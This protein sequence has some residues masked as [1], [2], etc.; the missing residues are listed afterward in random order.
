MMTKAEILKK[1]ELRQSTI[2]DYLNCPLL[3]RYKHLEEI[4]ESYRHSAALHGTALHKVIHRLHTEDWNLDLERAYKKAL[5]D[6]IEEEETPVNW[7]ETPE[8][9]LENAVEILTGYRNNPVNQ[10]AVVL[11][12][13]VPF[14]VKVNGN[15]FTGTIDQVRR[16]PDKTVE[17]LDLKSSK[18]Q[19]SI[20]F[21]KNDWQLNLYLYA[22]LNGELYQD[23]EWIKAGITP[24]YVGWY[25]L[26]HHEI[27][28]RST[29]NGKAGEEKGEPLIKITKS[30]EDMKLFKAELAHLLKVMLKDWHF[31]NPNHCQMCAMTAYCNSRSQEMYD[32]EMTDE[33]KN[34]IA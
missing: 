14:R 13:E 3:F 20:S 18:Q 15:V 26:R 7:K 30:D 1:I 34:L 12:S 31:P 16:N 6:A 23:D 27:R 22:L 33:I 29:V 19:P 32:L 24:D 28:K 8:K 9:Y 2:K 25:F 4:P 21:L 17:L 5:N 10:E 11:Y